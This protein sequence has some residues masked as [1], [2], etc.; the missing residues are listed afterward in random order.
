MP[1]TLN[2]VSYDFFQRASAAYTLAGTGS[3]G[4]VTI[5]SAGTTTPVPNVLGGSYIWT[6]T[7]TFSGGSTIAL[8][9]LGP[10]ATTWVTVAT[11]TASG[12]TGVVLGNNATVRLLGSVASTTGVNSSLT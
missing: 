11:A 12:S 6:T 5:A 1:Q 8:Q 10:D 4:G 2:E 3:G 9:A 7:G